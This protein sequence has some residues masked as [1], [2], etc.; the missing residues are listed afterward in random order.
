MRFKIVALISESPEFSSPFP[1]FP[2]L[3][4]I[5]AVRTYLVQL[6]PF[7]QKGIIK[8]PKNAK[9]NLGFILA[10]LHVYRIIEADDGQGIIESLRA[11]STKHV[12]PELK[13]WLDFC[14]GA[15]AAHN[16]GD[17]QKRGDAWSSI[18]ES[19]M[20]KPEDEQIIKALLDIFS[21]ED[22]DY[23][24]VTIEQIRTLLT[25]SGF[26]PTVVLD[27]L[28]TN[29]YLDAHNVPT[30]EF[31]ELAGALQLD[32]VSAEVSANLK[33]F[34]THLSETASISSEGYGLS[35]TIRTLRRMLKNYWLA[36]DTRTGFMV[37]GKLLDSLFDKS[38]K[39]TNVNIQRLET[40]ICFLPIEL[41]FLI[42]KN[43]RVISMAIGTSRHINA[44]DLKSERN[45]EGNV[46][47]MHHDDLLTH[48]HPRLGVMSISDLLKSVE[49]GCL[50]I[51]A[52]TVHQTHI[53]EITIPHKDAIKESLDFLNKHSSISRYTDLGDEAQVA[54][55]FRLLEKMK[56]I[57]ITGFSILGPGID[58]SSNINRAVQ[59][60]WRAG[61]CD[62][63]GA[64]QQS[65]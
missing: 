35:L 52:V 16:V 9:D 49:M 64:R 22:S 51:R 1:E 58:L 61:I 27:D 34:L 26:E 46:A 10:C 14:F 30:E 39:G 6:S 21:D 65:R 40:N 63:L 43:S 57:K 5:S 55:M 13:A 60:L 41:G 8:R 19:G 29:G 17:P 48:N 62:D 4:D 38:I 32:T 2:N 25:G 59:E 20:Q 11:I 7:L 47:L 37:D 36:Q 12:C 44:D 53:V 24:G 33:I 31:T 54:I 23:G 42:D 3:A 15:R 45:C 50:E 18:F 28:K 56:L